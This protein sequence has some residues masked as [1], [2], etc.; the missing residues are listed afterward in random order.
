MSV[1]GVI[2]YT[3]IFFLIGSLLIAFALGWLDVQQ[4]YKI[5]E[6]AQ[7]SLNSKITTGLIGLLL[8]LIS[9]S[10]A[11]LILGRI[12]KEKTIAF[13][14][15]TGQ[16]TIALSAVEDL[17]KRLTQNIAEIKEMRP[18]VIANKRGVEVKLRVV[19]HSEVNIP[20]LTGHLQEIIKTKIQEMLG[21]EEQII[22][23]VH[24]A[25]IVTHGEKKKKDSTIEETIP[26]Y[27]GYRR[28]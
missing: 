3:M 12:E 17:I 7:I 19:L 23:K 5:V 20:D 2:F 8:I 18:D 26:P 27:S 10:F 14:T 24:V 6:Y 28:T 11:Q 15:P 25:K 13:S 21:I 4:I 16:V 22:V 9:I 1:F